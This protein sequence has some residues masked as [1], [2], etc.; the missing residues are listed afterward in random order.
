MSGL[1]CF[2]P[3]AA[4]VFREWVPAWHFLPQQE[5]RVVLH[6]PLW[7]RRPLALGDLTSGT[8]HARGARILGGD[9]AGDRQTKEGELGSKEGPRI[10]PGRGS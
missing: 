9:T 3:E 1:Y 7:P 5:T 6:R 2:W 10:L 4:A 8:T